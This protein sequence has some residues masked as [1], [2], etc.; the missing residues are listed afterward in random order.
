MLFLSQYLYLKKAENI[1]ITIQQ[2][3]NLLNWVGN[4]SIVLTL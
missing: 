4:R 2:L 1:T 3:S